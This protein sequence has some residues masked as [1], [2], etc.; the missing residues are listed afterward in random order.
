MAIFAQ[1]R[2]PPWLP[3]KSADRRLDDV[4]VDFDATVAQEALEGYAPGS[5]IADRLGEFGFAG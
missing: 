1:V 5:G 2:P 3:A 4:G